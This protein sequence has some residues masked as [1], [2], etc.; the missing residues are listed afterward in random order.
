MEGIDFDQ[1]PSAPAF[2]PRKRNPKRFFM[3][4]GSIFILIVLIFGLINM[5][6]GKKSSDNSS[7]SITPFPT[8]F[9][10]ET[11][12]PTDVMESPTSTP[13]S[14][15]TPTTAKKSTSST[16]DTSSL[17]RASINLAVKNG[18]GVTGAAKEASDYLSG[19]GYNVVSVGNAD[20][21]DFTNVTVQIK[22]S[23][24]E[25]LPLLKKD[26]GEKYTVGTTSSD[27]D[28]ASTEDALV[29]IGK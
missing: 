6:G 10:T 1:T 29:I 19:L 8:N 22:S 12:T 27:L 21:E 28:T 26:L 15:P 14:S 18:S 9:I 2:T 23:W 16:S 3:L 11:P 4:L 25:F 13:T 5:L 20:T 24:S 17:D 7:S